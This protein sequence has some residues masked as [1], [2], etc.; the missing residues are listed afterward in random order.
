MRY[1]FSTLFP[2]IGLA[3]LAA[4][5][6]SPEPAATTTFTLVAADVTRGTFEIETD[7]GLLTLDLGTEPGSAAI[8]GQ[9]GQVQ[10]SASAHEGAVRLV[11]D[12]MAPIDSDAAIVLAGAEQ[13]ARPLSWLLVDSEV[14]TYLS[15]EYLDRAATPMVRLADAVEPREDGCLDAH[16]G[17]RSARLCLQRP[18]SG[19]ATASAPVEIGGEDA[20]FVSQSVPSSMRTA[21]RKQAC[22]TMRNLGRSYW[23]R[24]GG[25]KLG[26]EAPR[27][28]FRWGTNRVYMPSNKIVGPYRT[29][30]F[31]LQITAP[32]SPGRYAFSWRMVHEGVRWF[33][34]A[35]PVVYIDVTRGSTDDASFVWQAVPPRITAGRQA[36][37]RIT[38]RNTGSTVWRRSQGFRLG[39]HNPRDNMRWGR[40]RVPLPRDVA[41]GQTVELLFTINAPTQPGRHAFQWRMVHDGVAWF[42]ATTNNVFIDVV[43]VDPF[44]MQRADRFARGEPR[45]TRF[46]GRAYF[47]IGSE[48]YFPKTDFLTVKDNYVYANTHCFFAYSQAKRD[49]IAA[50]LVADGYNSIYLY[51]LNQGDYGSH[52]RISPYGSGGWSFNTNALNAS[53][54]ASWRAAIQ[55]LVDVYKLKPFIWLAADDSPAINTAPMWKMRQY[56]THMKNAFE[57][58]P[59]MWVLGLEVDEYWTSSEVTQIANHLRGLGT[60]HMI[61]V[62]L[63]R[64]GSANPNNSYRNSV[65]FVMLQAQTQQSDAFYAA[66]AA[67]QTNG[68]KPCIASEYNIHGEGRSKQVGAVFAGAG[69]PLPY[70]AGLGN[71]IGGLHP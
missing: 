10:V 46:A 32:S 71:G 18:S 6:A 52:C 54:V 28:N 61:G 11:A 22:V 17:E 5:E 4:C 8:V 55:R 21:E 35:S 57:D 30:T 34:S 45:A 24:A 38:V 37:A 60:R 70:V 69:A 12:D 59:V 44:A 14:V 1:R 36:G 23:S 68:A 31:C 66:T 53:R 65:D 33:G 39:S 67:S 49:E 58:M 43:P 29:H 15:L 3:A 9:D 13:D 51:T 50:A 40:N 16:V 41:P 63:T 26:S 2:L 42:G 27:D 62:H 47:A 48:L 19:E 64:G 25:Y 56:V 20:G 7:E